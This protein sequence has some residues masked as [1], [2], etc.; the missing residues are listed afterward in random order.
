MRRLRLVLEYDGTGFHGFQKQPVVRTV[1][2]EIEMR[3]SAACGHPVETVAAGRTDAGVHAL[4]QV[5]HFDTVGKI[6][7]GRLGLAVN[8]AGTEELRVRC[9]EETDQAFHARF[10]ALSRTYRYYFTL[11]PP[12][13][14]LSRYVAHA[15]RLRPDGLRTM[16]SALPILVGTHDFAAFCVHGEGRNTTRTVLHAGLEE[17]GEVIR[18]TIE[19]D[20]FLWRMVRGIMGR[21]FEIGRGKRDPDSLRIELK[22]AER[23]ASALSAPAN[24]LFLAGVRYEDGYPGEGAVGDLL[25]GSPIW[26]EVGGR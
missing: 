25:T 26:S 15:A 1:Q 16:Q 13:P 12:T 10:S 2:S 22:R 5:V 18:F 20:G 14:T 4:G 11:S 7:A 21:L 8:G 9:V 24:G 19:A 17:C 3:L 6:P 23:A